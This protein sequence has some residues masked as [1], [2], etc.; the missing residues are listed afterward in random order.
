MQ[1]RGATALVTGASGGL[2][3]AIARDLAGR[4]AKLVLTARRT[5]AI[6]ALA[7]ELG[8][9]AVTADL[10]DRADVDRLGKQCGDIDL[11]VANAGTGSD[12]SL[13]EVDAAE[14]DFSLDVNLRAPILLTTAFVQGHQAS[15]RPGHV[16]LIGSL[17]GLAPSPGT[18]LY[19]A[20]KFGLRGFALSVRQDLHGS[21]V[22]L[23]IVEP[24]FIRDAG[25]FHEG[26]IE[27]PQ[28]VR[29][30]APDDVA[31]GVVRAIE[32]DQAEVFVAPTELRLASTLASVA[33]GLTAAVMRR[34][35]AKGRI[36]AGNDDP[37]G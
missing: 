21:D 27:L 24:G 30:C 31:R 1:I 12:L 28:G 33:P 26:G 13:A 37:V 22:G 4:G 17:S 9:K 16:V 25:M 6:E 20:T 32:R 7:E 14:V 29:T 3:Q 23:S 35:D 34:V 5:A 2:G 19:N 15:G 8:A 11:L 18:F 10:T 36:P